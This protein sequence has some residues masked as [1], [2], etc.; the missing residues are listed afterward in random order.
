MMVVVVVAAKTFENVMKL[1]YKIETE[2]ETSW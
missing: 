2:N 1:K